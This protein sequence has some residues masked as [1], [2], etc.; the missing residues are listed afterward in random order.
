MTFALSHLLG[1]PVVHSQIE[2]LSSCV[3][4]FRIAIYD[5][6]HLVEPREFPGASRRSEEL[7][8]GQYRNHMRKLMLHAYLHC[9]VNSAHGDQG[10][11]RMPLDDIDN[12]SVA[13]QDIM[14]PAGLLLPHEPIAVVGAGYDKLVP[15][16]QEVDCEK[17]RCMLMQF[18]KYAPSLTVSTLQAPAKR[19]RGMMVG[20][21]L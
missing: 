3:G 21:P 4:R 18:H 6:I 5:R 10:Q 11:V 8:P 1:Q 2:K 12:G 9:R 7:K 14:Q 17:V 15:R 16:P 19:R 13:L 20:I